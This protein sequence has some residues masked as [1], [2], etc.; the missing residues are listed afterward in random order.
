[1]KP[2]PIWMAVVNQIDEVIF[3]RACQN[4]HQAE[5][6]IVGY[7]RQNEEFDGKRFDDACFWIGEKD[8][9]L[10]LMVF[11]MQPEDFRDV[12]NRLAVFRSDLPL[13]EKGLYRVIYE[14]DVGA[15]SA[16]EAARTVHEIM[17][18]SDSL[19]PVLDVINSKGSKIR[20]DLSQRKGKG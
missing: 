7:L 19:P 3:S 18:D 16:V 13:R 1:M 15:S 4:R 20:I 14:I 5:K 6:A 8:L 11:A 2:K 10:D 17:N 12:W 9:R